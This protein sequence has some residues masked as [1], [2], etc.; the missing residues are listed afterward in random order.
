MTG[1]LFDGL[2]FYYNDITLEISESV[3][4]PAEDSLLLAKRIEIEDLAG[5]RCLDMGCGSGFLAVLMAKRG[6]AVAAADIDPQAAALTARNARLN[7][8]SVTAT[9]S[10]LFSSVSGSYDFIAFNPPYLPVEGE[11]RQWSGGPSGRDVIE[12]FL[13]HLPQHLAENGKVMMAFSSLTGEKEVKELAEENGF[14]F[15]VAER[16]K[17]SWEELIVAEIKFGK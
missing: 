6:G 14:S 10:D 3:Y 13:Q 7:N 2:K 12:K 9:V 11:S 15:S 16:Q 5:K 8:V 1:G 17:V 4:G